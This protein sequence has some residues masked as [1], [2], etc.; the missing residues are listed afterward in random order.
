VFLPRQ[1][2]VKPVKNDF[3]YFALGLYFLLNS[4]ISC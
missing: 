2:P 4:S 3:K 1:S